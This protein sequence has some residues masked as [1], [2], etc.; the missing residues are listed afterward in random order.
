MSED[1]RP[2]WEHKISEDDARWLLA[3]HVTKI[4]HHWEFTGED[5]SRDW[6]VLHREKGSRKFPTMF[7]YSNKYF[8]FWPYHAGLI[9][10]SR[11]WGDKLRETIQAIDAW[12]KKN[13]RDRSEYERLKRKFA[14]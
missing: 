6:I 11:H 10:P 8:E 12:E 1:V 4:T 9:Q 13:Q 5:T 14:P 7:F 2:V 3:D